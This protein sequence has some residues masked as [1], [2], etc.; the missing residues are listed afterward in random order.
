MEN[1]QP[2]MYL[3][4]KLWFAFSPKRRMQ[5]KLI[6]GLMIVGSFAEVIGI[7][8]LLPFLGALTAP[9]RVFGAPY[10]HPI[11]EGFGLSNA[12]QI[13]LPLSIIFAFAALFAG[14]MRLILLWASTRFAFAA[15]ADLSYSI[16]QRT[17]YQDYETHCSRNSSE[18]VNAITSKAHGVIYSA[19]LPVLNFLSAIVMMIAI[20]AT[21]F[22]IEPVIALISF[23]TFGL[24]YGLIA[25]FSRKQLLIDSEQIARNS[26]SVIKLIQEGLGGIRDILIDGSQRVYFQAYREADLP[27]R[28]A[29]G[30]VQFVSQYPRFL[31]ESLGMV[32][33]TSLAY[34]L[35]RRD[36][37][38]ALAIPV[39]G[40][41]ALGA[42]RL[43]PMLQ[44]TYGSITSI[45]G[46]QIS[47][48]DAIALL[49]VPL[50]N[51]VASDAVE[52]IVFEKQFSL[53]QIS[54]HYTKHAPLVLKDLTL[55]IE[56]GSCVGFMGPTGSGKSTLIDVIMGLIQ[57]TNGSLEIDGV[58]ISGANNRSWQA[59][60]AHVPQAIFLADS[61]IQENIAF[62]VP[63]EEINFSR[64][65]KA[66][67]QAEIADAIEGWPSKYETLVGERGVRLSGGQRQRIGIARALYKNADVIIFDEA[68]S[69]LD[70]E[71]ETAVMKSIES[72][73]GNLT[74]LIVAHRLSTLKNCSKIV[75]IDGGKIKQIGNYS[76]IV[77]H[78]SSFENEKK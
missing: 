66:A 32:L 7:G 64:V 22:L 3:L 18:V 72:L 34:F 74:I 27:L 28:K 17:L 31:M 10:L 59:H 43:L 33:I 61:T 53:N 4:G 49:D 63:R 23:T 77:L 21:L 54:F 76:A 36:D 69:A 58:P 11:F 78:G 45:R 42:Q 40:T 15:G 2:I 50:P 24:I 19:I 26:S 9:N 73:S 52:P 51:Q 65:I 1:H 8:T 41:L 46:G 12:N 68:T 29:Q 16:Y 56:K 38:A 6:L 70:N 30:N 25:S 55:V 48:Q 71:T 44:Q 67:E 37:G 62:G 47:L 39:L 75:E 60:I 20:L 57:P 35:V 14:A 13:V 5:F